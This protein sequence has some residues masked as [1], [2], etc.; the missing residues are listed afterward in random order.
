MTTSWLHA[1]LGII[2]N[3]KHHKKV[4]EN[5]EIDSPSGIYRMK[6]RGHAHYQRR[7]KLPGTCSLSKESHEKKKMGLVFWGSGTPTFWLGLL[8]FTCAWEN[9]QKGMCTQWRL[10]S[11]WASAQADQSSLSAWRKLGSLATHWAHSEDWSDWADVQA[12]LSLRWVHM[13]FWRFCHALAHSLSVY[14]QYR[15]F[16]IKFILSC[17]YSLESTHIAPDKRG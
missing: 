8:L 11:A 5:K 6:Y 2:H 15:I 4:C 16:H 17:E 7:R 13:Q 12:D 14:L 3:A 10:R 1:L 9:L